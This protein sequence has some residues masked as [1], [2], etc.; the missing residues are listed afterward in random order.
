MRVR[1]LLSLLSVIFV[2]ISLND[3]SRVLNV[4]S[5]ET[6]LSVILVLLRVL[7]VCNFVSKERELSVILV[8][9]D[10]ERKLLSFLSTIFVILLLKK[11]KSM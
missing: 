3:I 7:R 11:I 6:E 1:K 8:L 10:I 2:I 5:L 4:V 9:Q